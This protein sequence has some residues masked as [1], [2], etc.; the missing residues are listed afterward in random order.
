MVE[1]IP[2][3]QSL[4]PPIPTPQILLVCFL[5]AF[6]GKHR[7]RRNKPQIHEIF[8]SQNRFSEFWGVGV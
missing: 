4:T 5:S 6:L 1:K 3:H 8:S 2:H 7:Q